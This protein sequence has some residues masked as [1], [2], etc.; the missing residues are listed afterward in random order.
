VIVGARVPVAA[1]HK[2]GQRRGQAGRISKSDR[3]VQNGAAGPQ[4][5]SCD[6]PLQLADIGGYGGG[7][8]A[9]H[10]A[11]LGQGGDRIVS[12]SAR[13][14]AGPTSWATSEMWE[15]YN[16]RRDIRYEVCF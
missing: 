14:P 7:P 9:R 5:G 15:P 11:L 3:T 16:C 2:S 10:E 8:W 6:I 1:T 12:V 4:T 13:R